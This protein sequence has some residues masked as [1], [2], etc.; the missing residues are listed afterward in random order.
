MAQASSHPEALEKERN[1]VEQIIATKAYVDN[2]E[3]L[4][5]YKEDIIDLKPETRELFEKYCNVPPVDVASHIKNVRD[6]AFKIFPYPCLGHWGFLELSIGKSPV[7]NEL[8]DRLKNGD[9]LLDIGCC[10]GQAVRKLVQ[11]GAPSEN[12]YA[13]DLKKDFWDFGLD[14]FLDKATLKTNFI[15]ADIFDANSGLHQLNGKVDIVWASS[16]FHLFDWDG[17]V[18]AAKRTIQLLKPAPGSFICGRQGGKAD[19]GTFV[20]VKKELTSYWHN[21]ESW[22]KLWKQVGEET[23]TKWEVDASLGEEDMSKKLKTNLVPG[24]TRFLAFTI[25]RV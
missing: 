25:R 21:E 6:G 24:G 14:L 10:L 18:K 11:D 5:W 13:S 8:L 19:P 22:T 17:Q 4:P 9:K 23:D 15:E 16:F 20:H 12:I 7:Y 1:A 3:L 2:P